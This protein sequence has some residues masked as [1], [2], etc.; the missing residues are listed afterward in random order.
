MLQ[1]LLFSYA[2]AQVYDLAK[3]GSKVSLKL[4]FNSTVGDM[5]ES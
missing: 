2:A 1:T 4:F 3:Y 5:S